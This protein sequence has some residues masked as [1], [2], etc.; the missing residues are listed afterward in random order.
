MIYFVILI[1]FI[2]LLI[3]SYFSK[4]PDTAKTV[5]KKIGVDGCFL[6][7]AAYLYQWFPFKNNSNSK[8]IRNLAYL[9]REETPG[10]LKQQ[11][12]IKRIKLVLII[13][14]MGDI[15]AL[16]LWT[17]GKREG[18]VVDGSYVM[19]QERGKGS[20]EILLTAKRENKDKIETGIVIRESRYGEQELEILYQEMLD[21]LY[22]D[23]LAEN[24]SWDCITKDLNLKAFMDGYPFT[25]Y[26]SSDN[27]SF[28]TG[29]GKVADWKQVE[30]KEEQSAL[31]SLQMRAEYYDFVKEHTFYARVCPLEQ[32]PEFSDRLSSYLKKSEENNPY[33]DK[34]ELP[35][36]IEG[37]EIIWEERK[38][39]SS[40]ILFFLSLFGAAMVFFLGNRDL[41]KEVEKKDARIKAEYPALIS[42]L[43]LYLGAGMNLRS[44]WEKT[45]AE[46]CKSK[47]ANPVYGEMLITYREIEGGVAEAE[48]YI[49]FG[50]RIR[51]QRY[52]RLMTL[53]VQNLKKGNAELLLQ[54]RQEVY[55]SLEEHAAEVRKIGEETGTKLLF[56]MMLMMGMVMVLIMVPAFFSI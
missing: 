32:E 25:L 4:L 8:T 37:E 5:D 29:D 47:K 22:L 54:L 43:T 15:L 16:F 20:R 55:I 1:A 26:W 41:Q 24:A 50:N 46:G 39:N 51:Q 7:M 13:V 9:N 18:Q 33:E 44:A 21:K 12:D 36:I 45:A 28:V 31:V 17:G 35:Q 3:K 23:V 10:F 38:N 34:V 53:L 49:R 6:C 2:L 56:P 11:Y 30:E 48:G 19:R 52:I 40:G 27:Y 42:K 14:F